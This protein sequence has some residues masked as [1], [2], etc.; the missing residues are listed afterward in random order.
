MSIEI[1]NEAIQLLS[2]LAN[3]L[4]ERET[5]PE[6]IFFSSKELEIAKEFLAR[7]LQK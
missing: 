2:L 1:H 5:K 3:S 4:H 6:Q 7:L